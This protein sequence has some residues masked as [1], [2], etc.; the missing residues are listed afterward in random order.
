[1]L[2]KRAALSHREVAGHAHLYTRPGGPLPFARPAAPC[3][4][5]RR[6]SV[7]RTSAPGPGCGACN[8]R[9]RLPSR[10]RILDIVFTFSPAKTFRFHGRQ[11]R[12]PAAAEQRTVCKGR[13]A[14]EPAARARCSPRRPALHPCPCSGA[15]APRTS[16][17]R[18]SPPVDLCRPW[19][20]GRSPAASLARDFHTKLQPINKRQK[21]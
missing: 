20:H 17:S 19:K 2:W 18:P 16:P 3:T 5:P 21:P 6:P 4:F 7:L 11:S 12:E 8:P 13:P 14:D 10:T 9:G 15:Q 1:M